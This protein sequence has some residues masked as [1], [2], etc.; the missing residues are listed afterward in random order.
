MGKCV[1]CGKPA[2]WFRR[3]HRECQQARDLEV[4]EKSK[5]DAIQR[6]LLD[7]FSTAVIAATTSDDP[8][9]SLKALFAS[10]PD[11]LVITEE[12]KRT[13]VADAWES[14][15]D[16]FLSDGFLSVDEDDRL[17]QVMV[18]FSLTA[19]DLSKRGGFIRAG[20]ASVLRSVMEGAPAYTDETDVP[21]NLQ[22]DERVAW[23]FRDVAYLEDRT[24]R[25]FV[26][27]SQGVSL[28]VMSGVYYRLGAFKGR[29]VYSTKRELVDT[30]SLVVTNK[31]LYFVGPATSKKIPYSKVV[32]FEQFSDGIGLMRDASTAKPQ[33]FVVGDGWFAYNLITNLARL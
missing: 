21:V 33:V 28:R 20:K 30:G 7:D 4:V 2:G 1:Y 15:V 27:G 10:P 9:Q 29:S 31:H 13:L 19:E 5:A 17:R 32:S 16:Q 24:K 14:A 6:A 22:K 18:H 8:V 26:G 12:R 11:G 3:V 23:V 25:E